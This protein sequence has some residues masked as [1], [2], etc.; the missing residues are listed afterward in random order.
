MQISASNLLLA[1]QQLRGSNATPAPQR[2]N[3]PNVANATVSTGESD[4]FEALHFK[5]APPA[6]KPA[7]S[8]APAKRLGSQLDIKV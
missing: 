2:A 6:A 3:P 7:N 5:S 8:S 4:K 1:A